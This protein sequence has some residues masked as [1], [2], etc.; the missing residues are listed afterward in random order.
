M[1]LTPISHSG[2]SERKE[3]RHGGWWP[4]GAQAHFVKYEDVRV[5]MI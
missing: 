2:G 1:P 4:V 3:R 5:M